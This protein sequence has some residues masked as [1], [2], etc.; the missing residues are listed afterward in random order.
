M[1]F[2]LFETLAFSYFLKVAA[3]NLDF[4]IILYVLSIQYSGFTKSI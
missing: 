1:H 3:V 4:I 2:W